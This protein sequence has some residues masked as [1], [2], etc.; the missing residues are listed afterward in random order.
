MGSDQGASVPVQDVL[1][2]ARWIEDSAKEFDE[3]IQT[4]FKRVRAVVGGDWSGKAADSHDQPWIDWYTS[5]NDVVEALRG[6][7]STLRE[8]AGAFVE[9]DASWSE[10]VRHKTNSLDLPEIP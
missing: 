5:A 10:A 6:D 9:T 1:A 2:A 8:A 7:A 4:F 3:E